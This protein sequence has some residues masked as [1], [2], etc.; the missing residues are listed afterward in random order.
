MATSV[1]PSGPEAYGLDLEADS[2]DMTDDVVAGAVV[3]ASLTE[4]SNH[5]TYRI[6]G[7]DGCT[8]PVRAG[9]FVR[10]RRKPHVYTRVGLIC[11]AGHRTN[12]VIRMDW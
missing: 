3:A 11:E 1:T 5:L 9:S 8:V 10:R 7:C 2:E 6:C 12:L 4:M